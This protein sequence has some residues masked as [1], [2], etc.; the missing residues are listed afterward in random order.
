MATEKQNAANK[1]NA[2]KSTGPST[3]SGKE[4][5]ARN[6]LK[7]GLSAKK[8][9]TSSE[10]IEEFAALYAARRR[11]YPPDDP[12]IDRLIEKITLVHFRIGRGFEAEGEILSQGSLAEMLV[13]YEKP[14]K[15]LG[16]YEASNRKTLKML[17]EELAR[18]LSMLRETG[19]LEP[20]TAGP[21][22]SSSEEKDVTTPRPPAN[23]TA[24]PSTPAVE[25]PPKDTKHKG[26][27][28]PA[29]SSDASMGGSSPA[30][31]TKPVAAPPAEAASTQQNQKTNPISSGSGMPASGTSNPTEA[32]ASTPIAP[33]S[34]PVPTV[35]PAPSPANLPPPTPI[36][37]TNFDISNWNNPPRR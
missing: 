9:L 30:T 8:Y 5:S 22:V 11:H 19:D 18:Y 37:Q 31:M 28:K 21:T 33:A 17:E 1:L 12:I 6:A 15:S 4:A 32:S 20:M 2:Q 3:P 13:H 29:T 24:T 7:H 35:Q 36:N 10:T 25:T 26:K 34:V 14:V 23:D 16:A 27:P